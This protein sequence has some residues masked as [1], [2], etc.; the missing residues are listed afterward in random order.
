LK[1]YRQFFTFTLEKGQSQ[2]IILSPLILNKMKKVITMIVGSII[3]SCSV[4]A[5]ANAQSD[6]AK[7]E[8]RSVFR[9]GYS[10]IGLNTLGNKLDPTLSPKANVFNGN[11]GANAGY[12][13]ESGRIFYFNKKSPSNIKFG[14]DWT[15]T[16]ITYNK[17]NWSNYDSKSASNAQIDGS[18]T[19]FSMSSRL[20]PAVSFNPVEK[21]V[22]DARFQVAPTVYIFDQ[23]YYQDPSQPDQQF[24][25]FGSSQQDEVANTSNAEMAK[26][27]FSYGMKT[28]FGISVRRKAIGLAFD[29]I[30]GKVKINY[31]SNEGAG[32]DKI[33]ANNLQVKLSL[34]L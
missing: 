1:R 3:V 6:A 33:K 7:T 25:E 23:N 8:T 5:T 26:K 2:H 22:I 32:Q 19:A 27:R 15:Y 14:I 21:L 12:C 29:Y 9:N 18:S 24:F 28:A 34:Q 20:G 10:R 4:P 17:M 31:N 30:L 13:V 16:S 11:L